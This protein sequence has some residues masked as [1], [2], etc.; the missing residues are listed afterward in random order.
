[1]KIA[2]WGFYGHNYGDDVM[3]NIIIDYCLK[4]NID[5]EVIDMFDGCLKETLKLKSVKVFNWKNSNKFE[6]INKLIRLS[7]NNVINIWGGGT[8]FTDTEGDGNYKIFKIIKILGGKFGYLG[9][10]IGK[11]TSKSRINKTSYLLGKSEITVLRDEDS[12]NRSHKYSSNNDKLY[13]AEDL[14]FIYFDKLEKNIPIIKK[15]SYILITWRNLRNYMSSSEENILMKKVV[16]YSIRLKKNKGYKK[17]VLLAINSVSDTKSCIE[18]K[19]IFSNR[20]EEVVFNENSS[21]V[22]ITKVISEASFHFSGRLHGSVASEYYKIPTLSLSYSPKIEYFYK[23]I[24][25]NNFV[26]IFKEE[27]TFD[28]IDKITM[29]NQTIDFKEKVKSAHLNFDYLDN[30]LNKGKRHE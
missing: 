6:K 29:D 25:R 15:D 23:S 22:N 17:I 14:S 1:M 5:V 24:N 3:L 30:Y 18:L 20:G 26:D 4:S 8:I 21:I 19:T 16:D 11:L 13:L 7:K 28:L 27:I 2:L 10:G 12:Y 9:V